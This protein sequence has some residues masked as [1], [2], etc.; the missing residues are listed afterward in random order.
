MADEAI[1]IDTPEGI[2]FARVLAIRSCLRLEVATGMKR[3]NRGATTLQL[4]NKA[5]GTNH[6]SKENALDDLNERLAEVGF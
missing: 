5:M 6:R 4:A 2:E 1:V 3:S